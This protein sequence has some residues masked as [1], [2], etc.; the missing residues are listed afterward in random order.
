MLTSSGIRTSTSGFTILEMMVTIGIFAILVTLTVPTMSTWV[1]NTR[2]R[3]VADALQNGV[4]LA[5][6]ESL[7]R[8]RQVV[9]ALTNDSPTTLSPAFT[10]VA[11]GKYW[12]VET[13]PAMTG[14]GEVAAFIASGVLSSVGS[15]VGIQ[16]PAEICFNSVGRLV[17]NTTAS[18]PGGGG[19]CQP[20]GGLKMSYTYQVKA[21]TGTTEFDVQVALGGQMRLC[22]RAQTLS[23]SNPYGC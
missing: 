22:D 21:A 3:A 13:I 12:V 1:A 8:S 7:R 23:N 16:G 2:V 14:S 6:T 10:A 11:S 18:V 9:F 20:G 4:R 15:T 17:V 19:G 5:Q